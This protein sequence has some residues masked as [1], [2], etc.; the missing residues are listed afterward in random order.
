MYNYSTIHIS[1]Y[2][3]LVKYFECLSEFY[4]IININKIY[5]ITNIND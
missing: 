3:L 2:R 4:F 5:F 1:V